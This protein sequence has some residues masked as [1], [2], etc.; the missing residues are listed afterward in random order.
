LRCEVNYSAPLSPPL[1][2]PKPGVCTS[3]CGLY[4]LQS[5]ETLTICRPQKAE[6]A[7]TWIS[8]L[9]AANRRWWDW[10][11]TAADLRLKKFCR[12]RHIRQSA[13][14]QVGAIF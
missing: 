4:I 5:R 11:T 13:C 7:D 9:S 1:S 14:I 2:N 8:F 6:L 12:C 3:M 10:M